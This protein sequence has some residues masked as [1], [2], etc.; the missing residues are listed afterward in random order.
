MSG[1]KVIAIDIEARGPSP[2]RHGIL[3]IGICIG[4]ADGKTIVEKHRICVDVYA[5]QGFDT[6]TWNEFWSKNEELCNELSA[7]PIAPDQ[8]IRQFR[9]IIDRC[10]DDAYIVSD[11][12]YFDFFFLNYYLDLELLPL[13]HFDSKGSFRPLHDSDSYSRGAM[14]AAT[15]TQ[16]AVNS[17]VLYKFELPQLPELR[18]HSPEDDAQEIYHVHTALVNKK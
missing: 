1:Q 13:L 3:A 18:K 12:P 7:K 14:R 10:G 16:W 9:E 4:T 15:S 8:A 6:K 17:E 5:N 11:A 2:S